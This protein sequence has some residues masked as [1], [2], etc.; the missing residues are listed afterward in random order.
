ML[1]IDFSSA[2]NTVILSKLV[3]K[4]TDLGITAPICNCLLDFLTNRPQHLRLGHHCSPTLTINTGVPQGCVLSPFLYFLFTHDCRPEHGSN[5]IIK[6]ADDTTVIGP[7][8][9]EVS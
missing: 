3:T 4:L 8:K 1:F 5:A 9:E 2:F 7:I 6:F